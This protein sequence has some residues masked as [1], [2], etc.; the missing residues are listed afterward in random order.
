MVDVVNQGH[1]HF[2]RHLVDRFFHLLLVVTLVRLPAC[3][4]SDADSSSINDSFGF[5]HSRLT[6]PLSASRALLFVATGS[7]VH[8]ENRKS[9]L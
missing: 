5:T 1:A 9:A 2:V 6:R 8:D 4:S 3:I 7:Y